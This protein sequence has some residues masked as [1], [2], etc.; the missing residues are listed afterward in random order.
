M[1]V[2]VLVGE[3]NDRKSSTIRALTGCGFASPSRSRKNWDVAFGARIHSCYVLTS[4]LQEAGVTKDRI[5]QEIES[6]N[7][8][9]A[10]IP[11]R[12]R[13]KIR[14]RKPFPDAD[15]YVR[16]FMS[17]GWSVH[18]ASMCK[19]S[20]LT[21][22]KFTSVTPVANAANKPANANAALLRKAWGIS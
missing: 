21:V 20:S 15:D 19:Q 3:A 18:V 7:A 11:L 12:N 5:V 16:S 1:I 17:K 8:S 2:Y 13:G 10:I 6:S 9:V 22:K 14:A 4:A